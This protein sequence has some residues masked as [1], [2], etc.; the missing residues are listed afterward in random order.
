MS[1]FAILA[2]CF[3]VYAVAAVLALVILWLL[4]VPVMHYADKRDA[5]MM[6]P[7]DWV[8]GYAVLAVGYPWDFICNAL[9]LP[10]LFGEL[11][12]EWTVTARLQRLVNGPP[13]WRQRRA[14]WFATVVINPFSGSK[15]HIKIPTAPAVF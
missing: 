12:H 8:I 7:L 3:A 9:V 10:A 14:L 15:P 4:F 11:P 5:G 6:T 2:L 1:A 13:G